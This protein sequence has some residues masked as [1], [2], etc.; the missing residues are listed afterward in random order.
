[1]ALTTERIQLA[2]G[3]TAQ[4]AALN[5]VLL[6][7]EL[8]WES[9]TATFKIGD[10]VSTWSQLGAPASG[11]PGPAGPTGPAGADN[12]LTVG[13]VAGGA[14]AAANITGSSPN[15]VLNLVLP[16]GNTGN[17]GPTGPTGPIG[18]NNVLTIG[19]VV[20]GA[21]AAA[22]ITGSS[23]AQVLN[24]T[25]PTGAQGNTG[26]TGPT[27]PVGANNILAIGTVVTGSAGSNA[28]A[29]ITGSSPSQVLNLTLPKGSDGANNVLTMGNVNTG[30]AGSAAL[31]TIT[32]STPAQ[33]LNLTIPAGATGPRG[34]DGTDAYPII[35]LAAADPVPSGLAPGTLILRT[36]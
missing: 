2:R 26:P 19:T 16:Q 25:L 5:P 28:A 15:Q 35:V 30:A 7:G 13:N 33:V 27:G 11:S 34:A 24:L 32:G 8:G 22:N 20:G 1:M 3:T 23:P 4:W 12:I 10:G 17:T 14:N 31:A 6:D 9:D 21:N 36:S 18:A 29:N